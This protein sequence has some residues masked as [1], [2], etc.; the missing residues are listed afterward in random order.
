M[1][2]WR[3]WSQ[4]S[5][6]ASSS[7]P[8]SRPTENT[9]RQSGL[10]QQIFL[11]QSP[12]YSTLRL[13]TWPPMKSFHSLETRR[14]LS[15][16][17]KSSREKMY[18]AQWSMFRHSNSS[19][20]SSLLVSYLVQGPARNKKYF[21]IFL[22]E[23]L[24][25]AL[26]RELLLISVDSEDAQDRV[27]LHHVAVRA[28]EDLGLVLQ[29]RHPLTS[30]PHFLTCSLL[31]SPA[32]SISLV[33]ICWHWQWLGAQLISPAVYQVKTL[34]PGQ[35]PSLARTMSSDFLYNTLIGPLPTIKNNQSAPNI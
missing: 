26:Q 35:T 24:N 22:L 31:L 17:S 21:Q 12:R 9:T 10:F 20:R 33:V 30:L 32:S 29:S 1:G 18:S 4:C 11:S 27:P 13:K 16:S 8:S 2:Q 28:Q 6:T 23:L 14:Q 5:D 25:L 7:R 3:C 19:I 15:W 34:A